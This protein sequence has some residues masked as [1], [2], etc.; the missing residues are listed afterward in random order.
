MQIVSV[1]VDCVLILLHVYFLKNTICGIGFE[2]QQCEVD[3][4]ACVFHNISC[5][6]GAQCV[7]QPYGLAYM[8]GT[9][10]QEYTKVRL[11]EWSKFS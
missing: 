9:P 7:D 4:D 10:C 11:S 6:P 5:N 3:I 8:C 1:L 2:G